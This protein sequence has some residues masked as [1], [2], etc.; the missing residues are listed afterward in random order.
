[1]IRPAR[2]DE[3]GALHA[4]AQAA[5]APWEAIVGRRPEPMDDDYAAR[6][7]AGQAWVLDGEDG[8]ATLAVLEPGDGWMMLENVAVHPERQRRGFGRRM[9]AFAAAEARRRGARELRL[10]TNALMAA[11]LVRYA[12]L[13]FR[14][15]G[16]E[17]VGPYDRVHMV[18]DLAISKGK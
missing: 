3:A 2:E 12:R 9:I 16:R 18:R 13:G 14:E 8:I 11:N 5:Y 6:V 17:R 7:H 1:M 4:L 15:A 10:F